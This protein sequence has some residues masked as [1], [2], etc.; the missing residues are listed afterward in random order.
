MFEAN[1][2]P[3]THI[4]TLPVP[5][6]YEALPRKIITALRYITTRWPDAVGVFKTDDD[7]VFDYGILLRTLIANTKEAYWGHT[8]EKCRAG[9]LSRERIL[10]RFADTDSVPSRYPAARYC[11]GIGYWLRRDA[12][13]IVLQSAGELMTAPIEDVWIG[14]VLNRRGIYP[15]PIP[16]VGCEERPRDEK[17]LDV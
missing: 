13:D 5:D 17:L 1:Y 2:N 16:L 10:S 14:S 12:V 6:T 9:I 8:A 3:A 7:I 11:H 15:T 4:L